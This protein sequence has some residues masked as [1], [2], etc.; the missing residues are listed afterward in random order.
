MLTTAALPAGR[1]TIADPWWRRGDRSPHR[2]RQPSHRILILEPTF[3]KPARSAA[4]RN[5]WVRWGG[6]GAAGSR[7]LQKISCRFFG[8]GN[9]ARQGFRFVGWSFDARL[10]RRVAAWSVRSAVRASSRRVAGCGPPL[11][12]EAPAA[13]VGPAAWAESSPARSVLTDPIRT[14]SATFRRRS[15][16]P[17]AAPR[18]TAAS[19]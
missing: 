9:A 7:R 16:R 1:F 10:R 11:Q 12:P 8:D 15:H 4:R 5:E 2:F 17:A 18:T 19:L 3:L 6:I 13:S 14:A